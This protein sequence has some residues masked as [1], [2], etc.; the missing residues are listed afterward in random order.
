MRFLALFFRSKEFFSL[1]E[2]EKSLSNHLFEF[3]IKDRCLQNHKPGIA[4]D[5][6]K[7]RTIPSKTISV[8][9]RG[10]RLI[11]ENDH[12]FLVR[13]ADYPQAREL[14]EQYFEGQIA[15]SPLE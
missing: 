13:K 14:Y 6:L 1:H 12:N 5:K 4:P 2:C 9:L 15:D 8:S 3:S 7:E 11:C 10:G